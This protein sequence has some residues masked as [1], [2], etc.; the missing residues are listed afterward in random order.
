MK[1]DRGTEETDSKSV[2]GYFKDEFDR[3]QTRRTQWG[4]AAPIEKM[5]ISALALSGGGIRSATFCLG[6]MQGLSKVENPSIQTNPVPSNENPDPLNTVLAR[7]DY[8]STVSGGGYIGGFFGSLFVPRR[9][10]KTRPLSPAPKEELEPIATASMAYQ[11]FQHEPPGRLRKEIFF[12]KDTPG[13]APLAWLRENGRY[14]APTGSGD[15]LYAVALAIRNWSG[16]HYVI[17]TVLLTV[18]AALATLRVGLVHLVSSVENLPFKEALKAIIAMS[19]PDTYPT[20]WLS[21][22]WALWIP[23]FILWLVPAASAFWL[24]TPSKQGS[25]AD[26]PSMT[27]ACI[28]T[29]LIGV[30]F[31]ILAAFLSDD[32]WHLIQRVCLSCAVVAVLIVA[33]FG[34]TI[35]ISDSISEQRVKLTRALATGLIWLCV[36]GTLFIVETAAQTAF[37]VFERGGLITTSALTGV[38]VWII[39]KAVPTLLSNDP[40]KD[41][42]KLPLAAVLSVLGAVLLFLVSTFWCFI[43]ICLQWDV[44]K[45]VVVPTTNSTFIVAG[46]AIVA[47]ALTVVCGAFPGFL[48]LSTLQGLY[49]ARLTRAY[50]GASNGERFER[51]C[52]SS[53]HSDSARRSAAEPMQSDHVD[54]SIYNS[55]S[56][57]PIHLINVC[58]NQNVDPAEQLVQRD[59]KGKPLVVIPPN[60]KDLKQPYARVVIDGKCIE[61]KKDKDGNPIADKLN[62]GDWI[63]VSGAA[64]STGLGRQTTIGSSVVMAL[65]N[66][67]LGRWWKSG[68]QSPRDSKSNGFIRTIF[69]TQAYLFD[70]MF[71]QYYGTRSEYHYLSDGGHFENTAI[72]ELLRR[73]RGV[74]LI[75]ACDC[76]CDPNYEFEDLANL[77]RLV[78]IDLHAEITVDESVLGNAHLAAVFG[79]PEEFAKSEGGQGAAKCAILLNV[80]HRDNARIGDP[81][82]GDEIPDT[83]IL[84]IKPNLIATTSADLK[85]YQE[86]CERFPQEPTSD[87][88][89]DEAQWESYRK[90]GYEIAWRVFNGVGDDAAQRTYRDALWAALTIKNSEAQPQTR[91][92]PRPQTMPST[93]ALAEAVLVEPPK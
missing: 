41:K 83:K 69:K 45:T 1:D 64:F 20:V 13:Q 47:F 51:E 75:V 86:Q 38:L 92:Q 61:L 28:A 84:L 62:I 68:Y 58:L 56:Y 79:R 3:T 25:I 7:F 43:V 17:G 63:G 33:W 42:V 78:R 53:N 80:F 8:I 70:E 46:T 67:R 89:Y 88:F 87:Q 36:I 54:Y 18:F 19:S 91:T 9:L 22:T 11:V 21:P 12:T 14:M 76:G 74:K 6:V 90:L 44:D 16:M 34:L 48:N 66:V 82:T 59:R 65:S 30:G 23:L 31:A 29:L 39:R 32:S 35:P 71:A 57:A 5:P 77:I 60:P 93:L 27:K 37:R 15:M 10:S 52:S 50:L 4:E 81:T 72:Y 24:T 55:N 40:K 85:Q 2:E 73:E 26:K 49:S